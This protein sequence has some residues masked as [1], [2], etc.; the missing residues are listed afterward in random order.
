[1]SYI[2][3]QQMI[4]LL[5]DNLEYA[6][7]IELCLQGINLEP[8]ES[9]YYYYMGLA[10]LLQ[11]NIKEAE[12]IWISLLIQDKNEE[13][14]EELITILEREI[15][16]QIDRKN[17][18][19]ARLI[20]K[21]IEEI[22]ENYLNQ[23]IENK[24]E[25]VIEI[26]QEQAR[27]AKEQR[28]YQKA[29]EK[30]NQIL[31]WNEQKAESWYELGL[32]Y[33]ETS[34]YQQA[35]ESL[36]NAL[37]LNQSR[38]NY[39]Y[40]IGL[41]LEKQMCYS[42]AIKAFLQTIELNA[43]FVKAYHSLGCLYYNLGKLEEAKKL[44]SKAITTDTNFL[45]SYINLGNVLLIEQNFEEAKQ[46]YEI[47]RRI[48]PL[49]IE[50]LENLELLE[51]LQADNQLSSLYSGDYF[52]KKQD[53]NSALKEYEKL[54]LKKVDATYFYARLADC[55]IR[56]GEAEKALDIY[57]LAIKYYPEN[58]SFVVCKLALLQ[59]FKPVQEAIMYAQELLKLFP[60]DILIKFELLRLLPVVYET[61]SE[62]DYY[63]CNYENSLDEITKTISLEA[64]EQREKAL[65]SIRFRT[66]FYITYQGRNDLELQKK[67]GL[68][69][70]KIMSANYPRWNNP[71][72]M[73]D[74]ASGKIRIGYISAYMINGVISKL[75]L[76]WLLHSNRENFAIYS[77]S[78]EENGM[79]DYF[80]G[81]FE[82]NS[83]FFYK[84]DRY[85]KL[86]NICERII[87]D[88]L[89]IL[90]FL[91]LGMDPR[92]IQ[93]AGL[94]LA[95]IQCTTWVHP[96]TT[97]LPTIDYFI[98]S[99]LMEPEE[100]QLHYSEQLI[101]LPNLGICYQSPDLPLNRKSRQEFQLEDDTVI[102]LCCQSLFKYLPYY[103]L[104]LA[105]IALQVPKAR[106]VFLSRSFKYALEIFE[107]RLKKAFNE[108]GLNS[109]NY[110]IIL[111]TLNQTDYLHVNLLSDIFLDNIGWSGGN[112]TLEA[113]A[114][115]LP[116]VTCPGQFMRQRHS[117]GILK[118]LGLTDTIAQNE[119][120]YIQIAV[121]LGLDTEWRN[122]IKEK[123]KA[124]KERIFNDQSCVKSLEEFYRSVVKSNQVFS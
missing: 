13:Y 67:Y 2:E 36:I 93:L 24:A 64:P 109:Q 91:D 22:K 34:K 120:E 20:K 75:L 21:E 72:P 116:V 115:G 89:H 33:Y 106:F 105:Q 79:F 97:G 28:D 48:E 96:I 70:Q 30:Y 26:L 6:Q 85:E 53:Y 121:K 35:W 80:T 114:C 61:N 57:T 4:K 78:L 42:Q 76:G 88:K 119:R 43:N 38:D 27:E 103:D 45:P 118:M 47:V 94:R 102:Y 3:S 92:T 100:G 95:P 56:L 81:L 108:V 32:I 73:P 117:Y 77:Y 63:R 19:L 14:L 7:V 41:V 39:H 15:I 62:I 82:K 46:L 90:V 65:T 98:S 71:I 60:D 12:N 87:A 107:K 40:L 18:Y 16:Q 11:G 51:K 74:L 8:N 44:Y 83:D 10:H 59:D 84:Y 122:I 86:E 101:R 99:D 1:M 104:I 23:E 25:E 124:N 29:E 31:N 54:L 52:Y 55:F 68:L 111:P 123:F 112:T 110:Y 5:L 113:I 58:T 9:V 69:V 37:K 66:N 50:V 17:L 49:N